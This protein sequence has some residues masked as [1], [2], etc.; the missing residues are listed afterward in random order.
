MHTEHIF[1]SKKKPFPF[2]KRDTQKAQDKESKAKLKKYEEIGENEET[3]EL[4]RQ[5]SPVDY[6]DVAYG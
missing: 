2:I 1:L 4:K 6:H 5:T 3:E